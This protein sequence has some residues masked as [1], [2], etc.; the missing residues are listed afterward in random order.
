VSYIA[1]LAAM[2]KSKAE[3]AA[4]IATLRR[5]TRLPAA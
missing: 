2:G 3:I 4:T 5:E 1:L